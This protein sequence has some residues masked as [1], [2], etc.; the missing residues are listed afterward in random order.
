M[1]AIVFTYKALY[2]WALAANLV[3]FLHSQA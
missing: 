2:G 1:F 3:L